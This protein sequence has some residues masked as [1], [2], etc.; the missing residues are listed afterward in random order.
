M[1]YIGNEKSNTNPN[2]CTEQEQERNSDHKGDKDTEE[3]FAFLQ[4]YTAQRQTNKRRIMD[5]RKDFN[6]SRSS[7][8]SKN[9]HEM[10]SSAS[11]SAILGTQQLQWSF[12]K[13]DKGKD[14]MVSLSLSQILHLIV[15]LSL[16]F[17][18]L[19]LSL[20]HTHLTAS[21]CHSI[22]PIL[23]ID[24]FLSFILYLSIDIFSINRSIINLPPWWIRVFDE[25]GMVF[26]IFS[27]E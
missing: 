25:I 2:D 6:R 17:N 13:R 27:V 24:W 15:S 10:T 26:L 20:S 18:L 8:G 22:S 14:K 23:P 19:H 9:R 7:Y 16:S 1:M 4:T 3:T 11:A 21:T 12:K 5:E